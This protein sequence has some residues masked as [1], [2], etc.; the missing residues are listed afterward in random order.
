MPAGQLDNV[1][2]GVLNL[3]DGGHNVVNNINYT[4]WLSDSATRYWV[5]LRFRAPVEVRSILAE[6]NAAESPREDRKLPTRRP[7][8]FALG[9]TRLTGGRERSE[10]LPSVNVDAFRVFYPLKV[11]LREVVELLV[12]FPRTARQRREAARRSRAPLSVTPARLPARRREPDGWPRFVR[13]SLPA[14]VPAAHPLPGLAVSSR[15]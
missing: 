14:S 8:G 9:V 15:S 13:V 7:E 12:A 3:F 1:F 10:K 6:F 4:Y 5:K 2:Y 11:P